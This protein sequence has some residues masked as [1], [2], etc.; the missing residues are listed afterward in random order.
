MG[1]R[2]IKYVRDN[3]EFGM[4]NVDSF[5]SADFMNCGSVVGWA[6]P[7]KRQSDPPASPELERWRAGT[8]PK[9]FISH[10]SIVSI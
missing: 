1:T 6:V 3:D 8:I 9:V 5:H 2:E 4:M 10:Y 7:T